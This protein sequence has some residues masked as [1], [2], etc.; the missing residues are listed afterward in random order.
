[1]SFF[2]RRIRNHAEAEDL[3]QEVFA[4]LLTGETAQVRSPDSYVFQVAA[5]LLTDRGRRQKVRA[6]YREMVTNLDGQDIEPLDPHRILAARMALTNFANCLAALPERTRVF[7]ILYRVENMSLDAIA[8]SYGI[9]KSA[10]KKHV[11]K[12]M[13]HI[14]ARMRDE[15]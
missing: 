14:L 3:T 2:L 9:S 7:F 13:A 11:A 4:R 1:M 5:N 8:E 12:A 15:Q 6:E 10:V